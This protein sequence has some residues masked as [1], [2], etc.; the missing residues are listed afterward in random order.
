MKKIFL[1]S[2]YNGNLKRNENI[3]MNLA[4]TIAKADLAVFAPHLFYTRF[5]SEQF[6]NRRIGIM[7]GLEFLRVCDELWYYMPDGIKTPGMLD[8]IT[9]AHKAGV[10]VKQIPAFEAGQR[11]DNPDWVYALKNSRDFETL[12]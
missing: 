8:E 12:D 4:K 3:A 6:S 7:S 5:L 10:K 9:E 11:V 1:S 2:P